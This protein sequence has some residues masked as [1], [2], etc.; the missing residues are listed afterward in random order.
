MTLIVT[1]SQGRVNDQ[2]IKD[3]SI[4]ALPIFD[5]I[6]HP[7]IAG[8]PNDFETRY[9][10]EFYKYTGLDI[11]TET[12]FN[13]PYPAITEKTLR[14]IAS[15][16]MFVILGPHGVLEMLRSRGF[17]TFGDIIDE[18]YDTILDPS[19]R[20]HAVV[21]VVT[22]FTNLDLDQIR[23]YYNQNQEKFNHNFEVLKNLRAI[24]LKSICLKLGISRNNVYNKNL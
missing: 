8:Q 19:E 10:A 18:S 3:G 5:N 2:F 4:D 16:R 6:T 17:E 9:Q 23:H 12:V 24:E 14:P 15:K 7:L 21:K 11:V 20:F 13:Y 22:K 1:Q